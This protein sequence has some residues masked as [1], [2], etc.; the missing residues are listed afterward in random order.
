MRVLTACVALVAVV[1]ALGAC[2]AHGSQSRHAGSGSRNVEGMPCVAAC[3][4]SDAM[5]ADAEEHYHE[6]LQRVHRRHRELNAEVDAVKQRL[7]AEQSR[8]ESDVA[9]DSAGHARRMASNVY[10]CNPATCVPPN[11]RCA[12]T[13]NPGGFTRENTPQFVRQWP[14]DA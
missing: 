14:V 3:Q 13:D 2:P 8:D 6:H 4:N 5:P 11:C 12:T 10:T 9:G 1:V 7:S